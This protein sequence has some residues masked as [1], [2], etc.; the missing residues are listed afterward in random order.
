MRV[1]NANAETRIGSGTRN[2]NTKRKGAIEL[3]LGFIVMIVFAVVLLSLAIVWL[4]GMMESVS[5]LTESQIASANAELDE[6]FQRQ[7]TVFALSKSIINNPPA[8]RGKAYPISVGF[9]NNLDTSK[10]DS[11]G[12]AYFAVDVTA[13]GGPGDEA[14]LEE[15]QKWIDCKPKTIWVQKG[16]VIGRIVCSFTAAASA[17]MG[18]YSY[19]FEGCTSTQAISG[20]CSGMEK[21]GGAPLTLQVVIK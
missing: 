1:K 20:G 5:G 10:L 15:Y 2:R 9:K 3:S 7:L 17:D 6:V 12:N 4:R 19:M 13:I 11:Q 14:K 16:D 8:T 21:F 18:T